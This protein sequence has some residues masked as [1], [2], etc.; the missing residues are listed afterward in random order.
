MNKVLLF[1]PRAAEHKPRIPNSVLQVAASIEG[2]Y[3]WSIV[4]GNI[5][6]APVAKLFHYLRTGEY[7]YFG[8]TVMPGPQLRQA[9]IAS[10]EI[11]KNFPSV[12]IA[13]GGY[14]PSNQPEVCLRSGYVDA[15]INGPGDKSFPALLDAWEKNETV[16]GEIP[17]LIFL[18]EGRMI[19][20]QKDAIYEQDTLPDLPYEKLD[21]IYPLKRYLGKTYLGTRTI[22]YHSSFGCPFTCSFCAVVP[23]YNA[24]WK[25]KSAG[26][27]Y[28]DIKFL[29][30]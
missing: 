28:N 8:C 26:K 14:F 6:E 10:S 9:I 16:P 1:N 4:D 21:A 15:I 7:A 5:E 12:K 27:I 3:E 20:T 25:G 18:R 19:T 17:N 29:K 2:K 13:W 11:R 22:A 23:V 30:E 24:R